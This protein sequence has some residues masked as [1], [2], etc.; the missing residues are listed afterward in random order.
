MTRLATTAIFFVSPSLSNNPRTFSCCFRTCQ[1]CR[2]DTLLPLSLDCLIMSRI[3]L[4]RSRLCVLTSSVTTGLIIFFL[5]DYLEN[6]SKSYSIK[7]LNFK[8]YR[9][10]TK[11]Y[12]VFSKNVKIERVARNKIL[13]QV[14]QICGS[15]LLQWGM[16][17][18]HKCMSRSWIYL[19]NR[20]L[21]REPTKFP[22]CIIHSKSQHHAN[23]GCTERT[24]PTKS[25][26]KSY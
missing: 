16:Q 12:I 7:F 5:F 20:V 14:A 23:Y 6:L 18:S 15:H 9:I 1:V 8:K 13:A 21:P 22:G 25:S 2:V 10:I 24:M 11:R 26:K 19:Y 3:V 4:H 17:R